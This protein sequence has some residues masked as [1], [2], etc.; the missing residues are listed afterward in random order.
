MP[1]C[2]LLV[3]HL[4]FLTVLLL[5]LLAGCPADT[6]TPGDNMT[7]PRLVNG[8]ETVN[9]QR[10]IRISWDPGTGAGETL[11]DAYFAA[12]NLGESAGLPLT[13]TALIRSVQLT[14]PRELTV[15]FQDPFNPASAGDVIFRLYFPD[16]RD[17]V[18]CS[19][20]GD[21]DRYY[22]DVTLS[23]D[24]AGNLNASTLQEGIIRGEL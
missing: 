15:I 2:R 22:L 19:H 6:C 14:S 16:R 4:P 9:D 21:A 3:N 7:N 11:P 20:P 12:V 8:L 17:Y 18:S 5:P 10:Q 1:H 13:Q 24:P 23:F